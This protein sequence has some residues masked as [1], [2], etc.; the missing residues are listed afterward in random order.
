MA[1]EQARHRWR[2][3]R[4][5]EAALRVFTQKGYHAAAVDDIAFDAATSKGGIY[6]HFPSKQAIFLALLDR[7]AAL[8]RSKVEGALA[9]EQDPIVR[10]EVA[11]RVV[12]ETF[13]AH[14]TL[15]RLFFVESLGAGR[16]FHERMLALRA[17]FCAL[18]Q[19]HLD[20]AVRAGAIPPLDTTLASRVWFGALNEVLT[21]WVLA[22]P[23]APLAEAYPA[24]RALLLRSIGVAAPA[25]PPTPSRGAITTR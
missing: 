15:A 13:A 19:S 7:T 18:I 1:G 24:L 10:A 17:D 9:A 11:L 14:R 25:E 3:E 16:E 5:L 2:H 20:E 23:P 22:E 8:L 12:L 6:H 4:I 21:A